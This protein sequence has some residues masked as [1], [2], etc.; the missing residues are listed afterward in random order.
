MVTDVV[1]C[2]IPLLLGRIAIEKSGIIIDGQKR[3]LY[4]GA[5]NQNINL[6]VSSSGHYLM[7]IG[8]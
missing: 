8:L 6:E 2:G 7:Q 1:D 4:F 5:L 3:K